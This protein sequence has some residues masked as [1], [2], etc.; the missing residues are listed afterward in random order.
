V[1][2]QCIDTT[3]ER[4]TTDLDELKAVWDWVGF[5][6]WDQYLERNRQLVR[7]PVNARTNRQSVVSW[8]KIWNDWTPQQRQTYWSI[9]G[10]THL[11]LGYDAPAEAAAAMEAGPSP[12][13]IIA[14]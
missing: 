6:N 1:R 11:R 14:R 4:V 3:L 8:Q 2:A 13:A 10:E 5:G 7:T 12:T 9:C